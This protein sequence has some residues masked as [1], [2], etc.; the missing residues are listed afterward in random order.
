MFPFREF[1]KLG[2]GKLVQFEY[3]ILEYHQNYLILS[4]IVPF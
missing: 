4:P 3:P 1:L 2:D